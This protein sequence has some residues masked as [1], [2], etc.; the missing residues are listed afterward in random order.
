MPDWS[1]RTVFRPLL[2]RLPLATARD[3]CLGFM[4]QLARLPLGSFVIDF[5]GHMRPDPRLRTDL[6]GLTLAGPVVLGPQLDPRLLATRALARFGV[7]AIEI[8]PVALVDRGQP[9]AATR[10]D[11][12]QSLWL[13]EPL[14]AIGVETAVRR[15]AAARPAVPV[16]ARIATDVEDVTSIVQQLAPNVAAFAVESLQHVAAIIPHKPALLCLPADGVGTQLDIPEGVSA[17]LIDGRVRDP[18]A[19]WLVG[20]AA[21]PAAIEAVGRL[22]PE[23]GSAF[24][25][26]AGGAVDPEGAMQLLAAGATAVQVDAGLVFAGPGLP[27]RINDAVLF[28]RNREAGEKAPESHELPGELHAAAMSWFWGLL[29]GVAMFGGGL[30]ALAIACTRVVLPYDEEYLGMSAAELTA[31][32]NPRLLAFMAHDRVTLAGT[33]LAVG[34][35][36][37][38]LAWFGICRG[39]HWAKMTLVASAFAGFG[40]FFL[41]LGFGYFDPFHAFVTAVLFQFLLLAFQSRLAPAEPPPWPNL[42][43]DWRWKLAQWGQLLLLIEAAAVMAAGVTIC[44]IGSTSVFVPEDLEFMQTT[45]EQLRAANPRLVP[46]VAHDRASFGGML[47][48]VGIAT[49]LPVL[50]G[51][52]QGETWLWRMLALSGSVGYVATLIVHLHVGY[53]SLDHLAPAVAGLALLWLGL[54]LLYPYLAPPAAEHRSR[55]QALMRHW[56]GVVHS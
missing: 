37:L 36:Y 28:A 14:P 4:G 42:V 17:L 1:Y 49:L 50:W 12:A 51:V 41:F 31:K 34:I 9:A 8:G 52:R 45:V 16:I 54:G 27:K 32:V 48:S 56:P 18:A 11:D 55:W 22:R 35:Q 15:L 30:L 39:L 24:P 19:G 23:V 47:L 3:L 10:R 38:F 53:T 2:F 21:L 33:M 29:L 20:R 13:P 43:D 25:I 46:V 5:L 26:I 44:T 40:T 6:A 7:G